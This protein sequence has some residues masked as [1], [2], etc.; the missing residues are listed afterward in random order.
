[1]ECIAG[2]SIPRDKQSAG[3]QSAKGIPK[4]GGN[5]PGESRK[6]GW[7]GGTPPISF[8]PRQ[9]STSTGTGSAG[10][11]GLIWPPIE[12]PR[13]GISILESTAD[14]D[15]DPPCFDQSIRSFFENQ[16]ENATKDWKFL[17][18][19]TL[20]VLPPPEIGIQHVQSGWSG[21]LPVRGKGAGEFALSADHPDFPFQQDSGILVYYFL[22]PVH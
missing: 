15:S 11:G 13:S 19:W 8:G 10:S 22:D 9:Q 21:R 12:Q 14:G 18:C 5:L 17:R 20:D 3:G 1:M 4:E 2:S 6:G 7:M 16:A